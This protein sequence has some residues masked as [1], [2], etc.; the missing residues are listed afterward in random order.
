MNPLDFLEPE[1]LLRFFHCHKTELSCMENPYT[2]LSQLRDYNL[3]PEDRYREVSRMRS[4]ENLKKAVYKILDQLEQEDSEHIQLFWECVFK[5][6]MLTQYHTLRTLRN[7]LMDGS[8]HFGTKIPERVEK[9]EKD[10]RKQQKLSEDEETEANS[11]TK[12]MKLRKKSIC[13]DEQPGPSSQITPN[14]KKRKEKICFSTPQ[15]ED[16]N[17]VCSWPIYKTQ[18]PVTCGEVKGILKREKLAK[19]EKCILVEKQWFTPIEFE[20]FAGMERY[21]NWKLSIRCM[22]IPL[23]KHIKKGQLKS[24]LRF[25]PSQSAKKSLFGSNNSTTASNQEED[26]DVT[27]NEESDPEDQQEETSSSNEENSTDV[28]EEE[29]E[30]MEEQGEQQTQ[31]CPEHY[32]KMFEVTCGALSGTL[33]KHRF[34]SGTCGKSIRTEESWMSPVEF[35]EAA[36]GPDVPW[37]RDIK[38]DGKPL[39]ALIEAKVLEIHS[40][41]CTCNLCEPELEELDYEK[42]D[43]EC[44]ICKSN[45]EKDLVVCDYCPKSF[46]QK[47][48][49]PQIEDETL[50]DTGKWMCTFCIF[51]RNQNGLYDDEQEMAVA[52]SQQISRENLM[53]C[54]YLLLYLHSADGGQIFAGDPCHDLEDYSIVIETPMWLCKIAEKLEKKQYQTVNQFVTDVQL[55]FSNCFKYNQNNANYRAI[56]DHLKQLFNREFKKAFSIP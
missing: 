22:G 2:F 7:S 11:V 25:R 20:R 34:A 3:I 37:R 50:R 46:H 12:K 47:C 14:P 18:L 15:K 1:E 51:A 48:H 10:K 54:Q 49:L 26:E 13:E 31:T 28:S 45:K 44:F 39:N 23:G 36:L 30:E 52:L 27:E 56:G 38:Y 5:E 8:F 21:K 4:K 29:P 19:G 9:R 55:I 32:K 53:V 6:I 41:R 42:N 35:T 43:D 16:K 40:L 33:H 17:D 24:A